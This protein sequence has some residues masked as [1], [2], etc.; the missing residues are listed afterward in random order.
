MEIMGMQVDQIAVASY[1]PPGLI[2]QLSRL[3]HDEWVYDTVTAKGEVY[4]EPAENTANLHFNYTLM[5]CEFEIL[6][7]VEGKNWISALPKPRHGVIT[8]HYG[9]HVPDAAGAADQLR[10]KFGLD[11]VQQVTTLSHT[12][13]HIKNS[14]RYKYVILGARQLL[15]ADIKFIERIS[16]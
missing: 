8:S 4:G 11:I 15:G 13:A 5:P 9:I 14:R 10:E 16:L 2:R 3:G 7:Y 6:Q 1:D 12:N